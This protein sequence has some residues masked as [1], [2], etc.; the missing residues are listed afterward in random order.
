MLTVLDV[1]F[2]GNFA[3]V[4]TT[5]GI[6]LISR[7]GKVRS[8]SFKGI[9]DAVIRR[10]HAN[11]S[12]TLSL[13]LGGVLY[14]VQSGPHGSPRLERGG[15]FFA[16][17]QPFL[18][19]GF[20]MASIDVAP[21]RNVQMHILDNLDS[22]DPKLDPSDPKIFCLLFENYD[23]QMSSA[24]LL[25]LSEEDRGHSYMD[26][27]IRTECPPIDANRGIIAA[28]IMNSIWVGLAKARALVK[29]DGLTAEH[30]TPETVTLD[31]LGQHLFC[32]L[33]NH[34]DGRIRVLRV[35][36]EPWLNSAPPHDRHLLKEGAMEL[37]ENLSA[38]SSKR[39]ITPLRIAPSGDWMVA[40]MSDILLAVSLN[41]EQS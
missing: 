30:E 18:H 4:A 10:R 20:Y 40:Q 24:R 25:F 28:A 7:D 14:Q 1:A 16:G 6:F 3:L 22:S 35:Q 8:R 27:D 34:R 21:L 33:R 38:S 26:L 17:T 15:G 2:N 41:W 9:P 23:K 12:E 11:G 31:V 13:R 36:I 32:A 37:P 29:L 5:E 19:F 39:G